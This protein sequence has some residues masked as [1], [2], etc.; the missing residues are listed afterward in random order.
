MK[1]NV[2][3][4]FAKSGRHGCQPGP[5][6]LLE[7][8]LR[9]TH[10]SS[11]GILEATITD[12]L[13]AFGLPGD[14]W[15]ARLRRI[16]PACCLWHDLGKAN[17]HFARMLDGCRLPQGT[18]HEW[19]SLLLALEPVLREWM[20]PAFRCDEEWHSFLWAVAG[21]HRRDWP[22]VGVDGAGAE[23]LVHVSRPAFRRCLDSFARAM[24]LPA[25][26]RMDEDLRWSLTSRG[27]F[28]RLARLLQ[29]ERESFEEMGV[30]WRKFVALLKAGLIAADVAASVAAD[31]N[32][33]PQD[34]ITTCL[35]CRPDPQDIEGLA[36]ERLQGRQ[37]RPFQLQ[38]A[39]AD[40]G[41]VLVEAG[42]GTGKTVAAYL[43]AARHPLWKGRR[44]YFCYP[45]TGTATEGFRDYLFDGPRSKARARL[46]HGREAIDRL[47]ILDQADEDPAESLVRSES[48]AAWDTPVV[49]C[50]VDT[51]LGLLQNHRRGIYAWP[52]LAGSAFVFDEIHAYDDRL[53][54]CLLKF[55]AWLPGMPVLLMSASLPDHR[56]HE[57]ERVLGNTGKTIGRVSGPAEIESIR[58]YQRV[59]QDPAAAA[60]HR[61]TLVV[62]NTVA[63]CMAEAARRRHSGDSTVVY[64]SRFKYIDR[65]ARH[66]EVVEAFRGDQEVTAVTTQVCEMSLDLSA[67]VLVTDLAPVP[68]LIQ[69]LGRLNR[70]NPVGPKP[71]FVRDPG[72]PSPYGRPELDHA[73]EW[74]ARLGDAP[75]SQ[76]DLVAA[77]ESAGDSRTRFPTDASWLDGG[78]ESE[79]LELRDSGPNIPVLME[80]D[81]HLLKADPSRL[82]GLIVPMPCGGGPDPA[83]LRRYRSVPVAPAGSINYDPHTGAQWQRN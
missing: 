68:A 30:E 7:N 73:M 81:L 79:P 58:R 48:L 20:R 51:V 5:E 13:T 45:T 36:A 3:P 17:S 9:Q 25:P 70:H 15:D 33:M 80:E 64:H 82:A 83:G 52:A 72:D 61:R 8:H 18:R 35:G 1:P 10:A 76:T 12:Q 60:K 75:L 65:V 66:K 63:R 38:V 59:E 47:L 28:H 39:E 71:F 14:P 29:E 69:R 6:A 56:R 41:V 67:D 42:C 78:P 19:V 55:L 23:L 49:A 11:D 57:L 54:G 34:W 32:S 50:T 44:L 31:N 24:D 22:R 53:F 43:R 74:L 21:H 62:T 4:L 37:P 16:L 40:A 2:Q 46:F 26:P 27:I 77:W